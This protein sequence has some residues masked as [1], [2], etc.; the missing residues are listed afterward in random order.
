[1]SFIAPAGTALGTG[2]L[3]S[4]RAPAGKATFDRSALEKALA[5]HARHSRTWMHSTGRAAMVRALRAMHRARNEAQRDEVIVP[6]YTCYSVA[7]S[8]QLAGL[9]VRLCDVDP[10]TLGLR[11]DLLRAMDTGRVLAVITA[12]LYGI[13]NDLPAI[14]EFARERGI[15]LLDDAAQALG[16][17][18]GDRPAGGFGDLGLFSFDKGKNITCLEGGALVGSDPRLVSELDADRPSPAN[19]AHFARNAL[20]LG[21]YSLLLRPTLFGM[22]RRLPGLGLGLTRW[23]TD[24]PLGDFETAMAPLVLRLFNRLDAINAARIAN[25]DRIRLALAGQRHLTVVPIAPGHHA[26]YARF[27]VLADPMRRAELI[28]ALESAGIGATASYPEALC[29]VPQVR[30]RLGPGD[31][32]MPG[33]RQVA[34]SIV[35]LPTHAYCPADLGSRITRVLER[36]A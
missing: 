5:H 36:A 19:G 11:P 6:A 22:V 21:A 17:R 9:R 27:P 16:A 12:N 31:L 26:V 24:Y 8:V 7:A 25:A 1:M 14:E 18:V 4:L 10:V 2:D 32:D 34:R 20:K 35:T 33:A 13:P 28:A 23:E 15:Y 29:D 30:A 3:W